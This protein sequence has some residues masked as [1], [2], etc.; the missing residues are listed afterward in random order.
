MGQDVF[1][2]Q[3][4][5]DQFDFDFDVEF[6][7]GIEESCGQ[8]MWSEGI[9]FFVDFLVD[10]GVQVG[11]QVG[12]CGGIV[13]YYLCYYCV[14]CDGFFQFFVLYQVEVVEGYGIQGWYGF[15]GLY[16]VEC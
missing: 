14:Y 1:F 8:W 15:V 2:E 10:Q 11:V 12:Q 7:V 6:L 13:V 5:N 4:E 16:L 3:F 9:V